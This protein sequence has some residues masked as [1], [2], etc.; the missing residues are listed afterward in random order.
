MW[1]PECTLGVVVNYTLACLSH[2][3]LVGFCKM[4][5]LPF[6]DDSPMHHRNLPVTTFLEPQVSEVGW[7]IP[8]SSDTGRKQQQETRNVF[9]FI[10]S[11][12]WHALSMALQ[13]TPALLGLHVLGSSECHVS[14]RTGKQRGSGWVDV[15]WI[16]DFFRD[17]LLSVYSAWGIS[18]YNKFL[19]LG[20]RQLSITKKTHKRQ[21]LIQTGAR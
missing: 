17:K 8:A 21:S 16:N 14:Y 7:S 11:Y 15:P 20:R 19:F 12:C 5:I 9:P 2:P 3:R 6:I 10:P 18:G 4:V 13:P 1:V